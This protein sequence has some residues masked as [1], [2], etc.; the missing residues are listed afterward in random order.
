MDEKQKESLTEQVK[1]KLSITWKDPDTQTRIAEDIVSAAVPSL[2]FKLGI[3]DPAFDW[4]GAGQENML[5]VNYC[6]Y[7]WN[8]AANEFDGNYANDIAQVR[9]KWEVRQFEEEMADL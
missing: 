3:S 4:S 7:E 6:Y 9:A 2:A 8:H 1:R 5:L